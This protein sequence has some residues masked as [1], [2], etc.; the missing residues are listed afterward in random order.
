MRMKSLW[1]KYQDLGKDLRQKVYSLN[2]EE[3]DET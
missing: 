1:Q 2:R 3:A